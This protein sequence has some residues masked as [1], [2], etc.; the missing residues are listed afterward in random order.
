M[1][2]KP[3]IRLAAADALESF[4]APLV[5]FALAAGEGAKV[6]VGEVLAVYSPTS[7]A[8]AHVIYVTSISAD[9]ITG[10]NGG[11]IGAPAVV[12]S[13]LDSVLFEQDPLVTSHEIHNAI[14]TV[15]ARFLWPDVYQIETKTIATPNLVDG[16]E[17]VAADVQ[18]IMA[19]WQILGSTVHGVAFQRHVLDVDTAIKSTGKIAEFDW[20]D[21]S[22]GYY[23]AKTKIDITDDDGTP[24]LTRLISTGAAALLLGG[25][26]VETT[27]ENTKKDNSDA[28]SQRTSVGGILWRDFLT[29]KSEYARE[30]GRQNES[31]ILVDRG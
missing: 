16:Q 17:A 14:S 15:T 19:A 1:G 6:K 26:F 25:T 4:A 2:E 20:I 9:T 3:S 18:E 29:L 13:A 31:R 28:V 27:L 12:A 10:I 24:D 22:A 23:T 8:A 11:M 5:S 7:A 30:L 21:G